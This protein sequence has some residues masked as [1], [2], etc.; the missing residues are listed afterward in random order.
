[1]SGSESLARHHTSIGWW[2]LLVFVGAGFALEALHGFKL[3][4]YLDVSNEARRLQWTLCHAHGTLLGLLHLGFAS[5][6]R[7]PAPP[8]AWQGRASTLL[9]AATILLPGGFF[10]GGLFILGGDPGPGVLL[11]PIGGLAL[12]AAVALVAVAHARGRDDG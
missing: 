5:T 7:A 3:G 6:L 4:F 10:L 1:M 2:T 9:T 12:L 11:V 8:G